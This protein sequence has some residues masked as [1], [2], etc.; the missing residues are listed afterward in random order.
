MRAGDC[1]DD[2]ILAVKEVPC[3]DRSEARYKIAKRV[4]AKAACNGGPSVTLSDKD[5]KR[6]V[7]CLSPAQ[8]AR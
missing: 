2:P 7:L 4:A 5:L 3:S 1:I 8:R 6:P